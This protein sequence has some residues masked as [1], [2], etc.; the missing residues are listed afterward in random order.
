MGLR[1]TSFAKNVIVAEILTGCAKREKIFSPKIPL[2][3]NGFPVKFSL[4]SKK[5]VLQWQLTKLNVRL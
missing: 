4:V 2:Y 5:S 1:V 3:P